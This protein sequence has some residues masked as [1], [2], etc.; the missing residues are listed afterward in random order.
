MCTY[1]C[2][3]QMK[4]GGQYRFKTPQELKDAAQSYF[5]WA[6]KNPIRGCRTIKKDDGEPETRDE[7]YPRPYTFEGLCLH[8]DVSDWSMF[9]T[10][11][12]QREGFADVLAW[13][14]NTI[15]RNQ[16]EG[17][18]VGLYRENITARLNGI[19][20][21]MS[22]QELPPTQCLDDEEE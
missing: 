3:E 12:K 13:I 2:I 22:V 11:N 16:I 15:R 6:D 10:S 4:T 20:E 19:A 9:C 18:L 17:G 8:I 1:I 14:R 7:M 21:N 5:D